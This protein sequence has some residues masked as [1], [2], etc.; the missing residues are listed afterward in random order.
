[1]GESERVEETLVPG[2]VIHHLT[3]IY[4]Q[5]ER[6][7]VSW[8]C[9]CE[10]GREIRLPRSILAARARRSCGCRPRVKGRCEPAT[11]TRICGG[12][13]G[14]A[15][16]EN[17]D[18]FTRNSAIRSGF[19]TICRACRSE[20]YVHRRTI[21]P[22][23]ET[24]KQAVQGMRKRAQKKGIPFDYAYFTVE[25]L[26]D[27]LDSTPCCPCC[28]R[29]FEYCRGAGAGTQPQSPSLDRTDSTLGYVEG[30]VSLLCHRCNLHKSDS[31][32]EEHT[33]LLN[34]RRL[35]DGLPPLVPKKSRRTAPRPDL[36]CNIFDFF[37]GQDS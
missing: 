6:G 2:M 7:G 18:H 37:E 1:M 20:Q 22:L 16:P 34:Y 21:D 14:R 26:Q 35:M 4:C 32:L 25:R 36:C 24:A 15:L 27:L 30:N 23:G 13:C 3:L 19:S 9:R 31:T 5:R 17:S 28:G 12:P 11:G 29:T 8:L 33:R 10:C